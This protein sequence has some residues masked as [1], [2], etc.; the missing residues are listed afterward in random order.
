M[1]YAHS[2]SNFVEHLFI[3]VRCTY[4]MLLLATYACM[5]AY[6]YERLAPFNVQHEAAQR[7][8][9]IVKKNG[10]LYREVKSSLRLITCG[11]AA[12]H[13]YIYINGNHVDMRSAQSLKMLI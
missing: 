3:C 10:R 4:A 1:N 2:K 6:G 13:K 8:A 12:G 9:N 11:V 5:R 7:S